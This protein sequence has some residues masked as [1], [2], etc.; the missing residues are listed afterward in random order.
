MTRILVPPRPGAF[1]ALGLLCTDVVHDYI[2]SELRPLDQVPPAHAE[3]I[4]RELE[5]RGRVE[6]QSE[7]MDPAAASFARE[8]DMRYTGQ[9]YELRVG[10]D[11][12]GGEDGLDDA[13]LAEARER[14]DTIHARIHGHAAKEKPAE[15]VSYRVRARV[16][17]PK[18]EPIAKQDAQQSAA[19]EAARK[20]VRDVWFT[21]QS[22]TETVIWDRNK[23]PV[24]S[25]SQGPAIIEQ[26]DS[27]TVVP[28]GWQAHVDGFNNVILTREL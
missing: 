23:L 18:Y 16:D 13:A 26:L 11:G 8:L 3:K 10:L 17:V 22:P 7:G 12:I 24:G 27:T 20:G 25:V 15:V 2:R 6:L 14:F 21:S 28:A 19:P 5:E 4:F 1:S 9:G